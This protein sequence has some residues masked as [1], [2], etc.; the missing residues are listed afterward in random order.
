MHSF[1]RLQIWNINQYVIRFFFFF[2][3]LRMHEL[4]LFVMERQPN[5]SNDRLI[6]D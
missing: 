1:I 3:Y 2:K 5:Y 6:F 4:K